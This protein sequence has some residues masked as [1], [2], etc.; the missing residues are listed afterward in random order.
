MRITDWMIRSNILFDIQSTLRRI[1]KYHR[2]L[3][4]GKKIQYP[5]DDAVIATRASNI[6]SRVREL[7]QY[8]RNVTHVRNIMNSYD[9][10]SQEVSAMYQRIREL[11]VR[12]ST[13]S[14]KDEDRKAIADELREIMDHFATVANTQVGGEH[15]FGGVRTEKPPVEKVSD[16]WEITLPPESDIHRSV[17]MF[18]MSVEYGLT[19]TDIFKLG[20]GEDV[21]Q[22]MRDTIDA[23]ESNDADYLRNV[24]L[25][26]IEYLEENAMRSF[27]RVGATSRSLELVEK[28]IG[29]MDFF[30]TEYLSKEQDADLT[31][32]VTKLSM[33]NAVLQ[34]ALK[35]GAMVLGKTLVDFV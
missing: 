14:L 26:D 6:E 19:V 28:R 27:A 8:K 7:E 31:E 35:S 21:F 18:G 30:F 13:D 20:T 34:A 25:R 1:D 22:V 23:L 33:Q 29:D 12:A 2:E 17:T 15:I 11:L 3:S 32:I 16:N 4:S 9:S 5:S 24:A 10:I